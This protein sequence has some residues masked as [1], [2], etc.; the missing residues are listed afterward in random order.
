MSDVA[1]SLLLN[2]ARGLPLWEKARRAAFFRGQ[3]SHFLL[4]PPFKD[5]VVC[6]QTFRPEF[7]E[8]VAHGITATT[9][10]PRQYDVALFVGTKFR[11]ENEETF[12]LALS[13][14]TVGGTFIVAMPNELGAARFEKVLGEISGLEVFTDSKSKCRVFGVTKPEGW[15]EKTLPSY[16][17]TDEFFTVPGIFSAKG[18]DRGSQLLASH[19]PQTLVGAGADL[20]A[21]YGFISQRIL[22]QC[23]GV[24]HISLY[25][26]EKR[27]LDCAE[28]NLKKFSGKY[29]LH[30]NDV[31]DGVGVEQYDWIVMNPPFHRGYA[32]E[33]SLG[34]Q[35]VISGY[36]ALKPGGLMY[37]VQNSNLPYR[38]ILDGMG[39]I[40]ILRED[41]GFIVWSIKK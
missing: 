2:R 17:K 32:T 26:A 1:L 6:Y 23:P 39:Q 15:T 4:T 25:E 14:L 7:D 11:E 37:V 16:T 29:A 33:T 9:E 12:H 36:A 30:W 13:G 35:F 41:A 20:G 5:K 18:S 8:L 27:A 31:T 24:T 34:E 10:P 21:G 38:K 22:S 3:F 40:E 19:L 28:V